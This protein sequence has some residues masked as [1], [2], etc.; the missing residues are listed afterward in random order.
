MHV[1]HIEAGS[2]NNCYSGKAV[3]ITYPE[4]GFIALGIQHAMR[5]RLVISLSVASLA[6]PIYIFFNIISQMARFSVTNRLLNVKCVLIFSSSFI[7]NVSQWK[8]NRKR[9]LKC[10]YIITYSNSYC[11]QI[12]MNLDRFS[13]N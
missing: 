3:S 9:Y 2:C 6:V 8:K 10:M 1:C 13:K 7:S 12:L 5:M 11:C 4:C